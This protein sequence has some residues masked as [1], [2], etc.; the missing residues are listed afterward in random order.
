MTEPFNGL[1]WL[2]NEYKETNQKVIDHLIQMYKLAVQNESGYGELPE[3]ETAIIN[4]MYNKVIEILECNQKDD[5]PTLY[6]MRYP[7]CWFRAGMFINVFFNSHIRTLVLSRNPES[8]PPPQTAEQVRIFIHK[9]MNNININSIVCY[10]G[11]FIYMESL[12]LFYMVL[13]NNYNAEKY[14]NTLT[15]NKM[16]IK[17]YYILKF[18][19]IFFKETFPQL[20]GIKPFVVDT[21]SVTDPPPDPPFVVKIHDGVH[22]F[23]YQVGEK[24]YT[25]TSISINNYNMKLNNHSIGL[26]ESD[27]RFYTWEH[28]LIDMYFLEHT[29][30]NL[31]LDGVPWWEQRRLFF[32]AHK[33]KRIC[34]YTPTIPIFSP[35]EIDYLRY[36]ASYLYETKKK[37]HWSNF[38]NCFKPRSLSS[39]KIHPETIPPIIHCI[40]ILIYFTSEIKIM[41]KEQETD[42]IYTFS[43]KDDLLNISKS[44]GKSDGKSNEIRPGN[45]TDN[46]FISNLE[47]QLISI[48]PHLQNGQLTGIFSFS[49]RFVITEKTVT[50][51]LN[52]I[53]LYLYDQNGRD[54]KG[55]QK[56]RYIIMKK[57]KKVY[58]VRKNKAGQ[59]YILMDKNKVLLSDMKGRY[60]FRRD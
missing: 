3:G 36:I 26:Y 28:N 57:S 29:I 10:D 22:E 40:A 5:N 20:F 39:H 42:Y 58:K 1:F 18:P 59:S 16:Y 47:T 24:Q 17:A 54:Q 13:L 6:H 4:F 48:F 23:F 60:I 43:S 2:P 55:G 34:I 30:L 7:I 45:P 31:D 44:D 25:L 15:G 35:E 41:V 50:N 11:K 14:N 56:H 32:N 9:L 19:P 33:G 49:C 46:E 8:P 27:G 51:M 12:I 37:P 38:F 21:S 52:I 53:A